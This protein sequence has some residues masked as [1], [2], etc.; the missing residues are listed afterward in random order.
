MNAKLDPGSAFPEL[1]LNLV[2][3]KTLQF[4]SALDSPLTIALFYRGHW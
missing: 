4:P 3:G 1:S 2:G